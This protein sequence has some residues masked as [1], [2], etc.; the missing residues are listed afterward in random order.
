MKTLQIVGNTAYGGAIYLILE[1][2][3]F[4]L[5]RGY[6]VDVLATDQRVVSAFESIPGVQV[7]QDIFI[8]RPIVPL[9][10]AKVLWQLV[11]YLRKEQYDIVHTYTATPGFLGR[12]S[13]RFAGSPVIF[14]HQASW[15]VTDYTPLGERLIYT[16]LEYIP[17]LASTRGICVGHAIPKLARKFHTAPQR[18]LVVVCNGIDPAPFLQADSEA[19]RRKLCGER[20]IPTDVLLIGCTNRLARD[21]D[22]AS[23]LEAIP[24]L[25]NLLPDKQLA[26]VLAG[27]GPE[28]TK[29][30]AL[31]RSLG[32]KDQIH[33]LGFRKDI[34]TV[35]VAVDFFVTPTLREGLSISLLEAMAAAK[36]I[37]A[38]AILPNIELI[39]HEVTGLMVDIKAPSQ[40]AY[41][42]ERFFQQP[43]FARQCAA[44]A[45]Q[46][47]LNNYTLERMLHETWDQYNRFWSATKRGSG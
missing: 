13:A 30:E 45:R 23:L 44:A 40:I 25:N 12:I 20:N 16:P 1:W 7:I 46:R 2:C 32:I 28:H 8:P 6:Q 29:L 41:A 47:V 9:T 22:M 21:K 17:T 39:E 37:V 36:P 26:V 19:S 5:D 31:A 18:K 11:R 14:H 38:T 4:L 33:F 42:I 10:D 15:T 27:D 3:K 24:V 43:D 34:A 35:L